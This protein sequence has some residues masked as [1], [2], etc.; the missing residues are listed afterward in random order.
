SE[1]S[2]YGAHM[3]ILYPGTVQEVLELGRLGFELS[4]YSGLWVGF[5][6][7]S[8]VADEYGTVVIDDALPVRLPEF[9]F[10]GK[11]W[12]TAQ[13]IRLLGPFAL[14]LEQEIHEGRLEAAA[15]FAR[16]NHLNQITVPT[17]DAWL[18][19]V[20]PGKTYV[21]LCQ[22]LRG[23]GLDEAALERRGIRLLKVAMPYPLEA[24]TIEE[25]A[26]GLREI[27]IIEEK[28]PFLELF[29]RDILY[30]TAERPRIV[31]K[32][33]ERGEMLLKSS[34]ALDADEIRRV[35]VER[36]RHELSLPHERARAL[37]E[38]VNLPLV[39]RTA[40]FCS[41]C[42][43]N[44]STIAP[45][46][47]IQGGGIGCHTLGMLME[48][49]VF[50]LTQM[51]GE[52]AQWAGAAPFSNVDHLFQNLG[53][54]TLFHSGTL[55]IRQ[56][57]SA[58]VDIT[59][60]IL[61]NDAVAMT[62]GQAAEGGMSV[63]ALTKAL[64]AEGVKRTIVVSDDVRKYGH[65]VSWAP[66]V[67]VWPRTRL[68]QAQRV[69]RDVPG[70]TALIYDQPCA[71]ELRRRRKRGEVAEPAK[72][73][74]IN[75]EVCEG[76]GDCGAKSNCLSVMPLETEFG[77][78]TQVHQA[79]CN[80]DYTCLEG[81][82][83]AFVTIVPDERALQSQRRA[84]REL[85]R[86]GPG[87]PEPKRKVPETANLFLMGIGGTGVVTVN[88]I[89]ATA[90]MYEGKY[91]LGLDQ[92]GLSQKGG[93]VVSHLKIS[94][95]P[96]IVSSKISAGDADAYL[97]FDSL[98][99]AAPENLSRA[100]PDR[101][102]AV[103]SYSRIPTGAMVRSKEVHFPHDSFLQE[104]IES[105]TRA[106]ETV[107]LD[108]VELSEVLF[109]THMHANLLVVG[110]AY[111]AGAVPLSVAS[112]ERAIELNGV[113]VEANV[114]AFRAGRRVVAEPGWQPHALETVPDVVTG[115]EF[116]A[117]ARA[118][119]DGFEAAGELRRLLEIRV[120][121]LID[122]QDVAYAREY[123][124]FI[125]KVG[126]AEAHVLGARGR[127]SEAVARSLYKL[128]AFKDEYEVA[129][130][131]LKGAFQAELK[132]RFGDRAEVRYQ[133]QPPF[134]RSLGL[135]H[136][137]SLGRWFEQV[138]RLLYRL[139]RLRGTPFDP[140]GYT[141]LRKLERRLIAEYRQLI[142]GAIAQ[143]SPA[144]FEAAVTLAELPD[145]IRGYEEIKLESVARFRQ[146]VREL[147]ADG[148]KQAA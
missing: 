144:T 69:L 27:F 128:M 8:D 137:L 2:L 6:V 42:P 102:I 12:S 67:E 105:V 75:E 10:R 146:A 39:N 79:S 110:A 121:E 94:E 145:M 132:A 142:E 74:F 80:K 78:K 81:D 126:E 49:D 65:Q 116:P 107:T 1:I 111:Q 118:L 9:R 35:F 84:A 124:S 32:R 33:D 136:K 5:K 139:R 56:A 24:E 47:S 44:R 59:Y 148:G 127:L 48:R 58:G 18:G 100:D 25:F 93:P 30:H 17:R 92:I 19:L 123:L 77:R 114:Q 55:A 141:G 103:V 61:Y 73:V 70:V 21:E 87:L 16:V 140:F 129:R 95:T 130:L 14:E 3:P 20:A 106:A 122:Y 28:R 117:A 40:Y 147:Q 135:E 98:T 101:T 109:G 46:G 37:P 51:G 88:Q 13:D 26:R 36:Y 54:G 133:L 89:L 85:H 66:G 11:P 86:I 72:R 23:L 113:A 115:L 68:E 43:H 108:A 131:H 71:A 82:C 125:A 52:G 76:C 60:K 138:Y 62:G 57:V 38:V 4:R 91:S 112:I 7:V 96:D 22:A 119:L 41:G 15:H 83:P 34:G 134:L 99:G 29:I 90:A 63:P 120:S 104:R 45:E 97:V 31:G 50:G 143:L 53:D 64:T